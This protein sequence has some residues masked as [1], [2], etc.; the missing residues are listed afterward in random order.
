MR[1]FCESVLHTSLWLDT[2]VTCVETDCDDAGGVDNVMT[3]HD[4]SDKNTHSNEKS[5]TC[6]STAAAKGVSFYKKTREETRKWS[7]VSSLLHSFHAVWRTQCQFSDTKVSWGQEV[8]FI[9]CR[10]S[11][12]NFHSS[13]QLTQN[14]GRMLHQRTVFSELSSF[15]SSFCVGHLISRLYALFRLKSLRDFHFWVSF[16][17]S[18]LT[19]PDGYL[20]MKFDVQYS[21]CNL[22]QMKLP[23]THDIKNHRPFIYSTRVSNDIRV[24]EEHMNYTGNHMKC[25]QSLPLTTRLKSR[26]GET[27][28]GTKRTTLD[29][30]RRCSWNERCACLSVAVLGAVVC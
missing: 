22:K 10:L 13:F 6:E 28:W 27:K 1:I 2:D 8:L 4:R 30:W 25:P 17:N 16:P 29:F 5:D 11:C 18:I 7:L 14:A 24:S 26:E 15:S 21:H 19:S 9:T 12:H 3:H 23:P 20:N